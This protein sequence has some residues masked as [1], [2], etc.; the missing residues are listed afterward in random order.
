MLVGTCPFK[1]TNETDLLQNIRTQALKIPAGVEVSK[2]SVS[3]LVKLLERSSSKRASIEQLAVLTRKIQA[4]NGKLQY[5]PSCIISKLVWL[6]AL[7]KSNS[8]TTTDE[9]PMKQ[10][11]MDPSSS[12]PAVDQLKHSGIAGM[13]KHYNNEQQPFPAVPPPINILHDM[14]GPGA[15]R[16]DVVS[17]FISFCYF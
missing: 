14:D 2:I 16:Y 6:D 3:I 1:G 5:S 8:T 11:S 13:P 10:S 12:Q 9:V 15:L 17:E 4:E 7:A